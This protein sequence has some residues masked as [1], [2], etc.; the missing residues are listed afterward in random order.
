MHGH[1]HVSG[2]LFRVS[3]IYNYPYATFSP[4]GAPPGDKVITTG[5]LDADGFPSIGTYLCEGDP[6]Y[7]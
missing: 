4:L 6:Y 5:K 7:W 2:V 1:R 3:L